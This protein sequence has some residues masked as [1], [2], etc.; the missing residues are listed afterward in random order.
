VSSPVEHAPARVPARLERLFA[1]F[2]AAALRWALLRP[3]ESLAETEGDVDLLVEPRDLGRVRDLLVAEGFAIVRS[4]G[5]GLHAADLDETAGRF[6]WI[7]VQTELELAAQTFSAGPL[8]D[9]LVADPIPR[10][11]DDWL[12]WILLL[13]ALV[14]KGGL[15][16]RHRRAVRALA[17]TSTAPPAELEPVLERH[18]LDAEI[19]GRLAAAGAWDEL[20]RHVL[21][22]LEPR[23]RRAP[24][25]AI[26]RRLRLLRARRG[27]SVAVL[28]PDGAG[29]TT[30]VEA[31]DR[32][33]PFET[34]RRYMGLTGGWIRRAGALR[35]PGLVLGA[36][37][38][39]LWGRY[40]RIESD[41]R[42]G[43]IV[44]VDRYVL[45]GAVPSGVQ[46][47]SLARLSRQ[48]QRRAC[49]LP[50]LVLLLDASGETMHGRKGEY[51]AET[52]E[53]WRTA[54]ARLVGR[55]PGLEVLD[56]EQP[57]EIVERQAEALI[58]RRYR[59]RLEGRKR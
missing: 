39:V 54:Y 40:L 45:D 4:H 8:L 49:P 36:R 44:L 32:R 22:P 23:G 41:R 46:L 50:D 7:H 18:G 21:P 10:P 31:L 20:E 26:L 13:R 28:G 30:L 2:A 3:P 34:R 53:G 51:D 15:A 55:V 19:V 6:L 38:L 16:P 57:A 56:A 35:V 47:R 17:S 52:L 58:W 1:A 14:D 27:L 29:K 48:L 42:L 59:R 12:L 33:L 37:L 43:R 11:A 9:G 24:T 25:A 5:A